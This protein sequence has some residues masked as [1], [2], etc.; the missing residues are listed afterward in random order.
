MLKRDTPIKDEDI[1]TSSTY[2][3]NLQICGVVQKVPNGS[4]M[5]VAFGFP[6]G[7]DANDAGTT[8]KIYHYKHDDRGNITG[9]EEIPVII[10]EYGLI[11]KVTSFSPF[12][13]V[14]VKNTSAAVTES[15]VK[16]VYAYVNGTG[17]TVTTDGA[18]GIAAVEEDV[19]YDI[20]PDK[21]YHTACVRLNGKAIEAS[22]YANGK[23]TLSAAELEAGN[24]LEV[25]FVTEESAKSYASKGISIFYYGEPV[26]AINL[27]NAAAVISCCVI[28]VVA[29]GVCTFMVWWFD[30]R[31][32]KSERAAETSSA[33][34]SARK[35]K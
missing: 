34:R 21:G 12:T 3:I 35:K 9:V 11:A 25:C 23:L 6:E 28:G 20:S 24:M 10:T 30:L 22:R 2:E 13:I 27:V 5:Q 31:T 7:Y 18:S 8:F 26:S 4:Y 15:N 33:K 16:N 32:P 29:L 17:G 1:V 19:V 14:Q